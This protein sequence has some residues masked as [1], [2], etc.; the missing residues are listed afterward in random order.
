MRHFCCQNWYMCSEL[1]LLHKINDDTQLV[2][3]NTHTRTHARTHTHIDHFSHKSFISF[4]SIV[5][6][7]ANVCIHQNFHVIIIDQW[8]QTARLYEIKVTFIYSRAIL[9]TVT[10]EC[11]LKRVICKTWSGRVANSVDPDQTPQI[12]ASDQGLQCLLEVQDVKR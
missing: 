10:S 4:W 1:L 6:S 8:N 3:T 7:R 9:D 2:N 12:V 5:Y 11:R